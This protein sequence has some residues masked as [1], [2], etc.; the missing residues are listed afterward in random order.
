MDIAA[1]STSLSMQSVQQA[2][3]VNLLKKTMEQAEKSALSAVSAI[4][5]SNPVQSA[6]SN[7]ILDVKV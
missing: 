5:Q 6:P 4:E 3:S 1:L 7:H 2:V